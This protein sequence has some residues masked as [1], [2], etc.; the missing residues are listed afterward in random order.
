MGAVIRP[1]DLHPSG[2]AGQLEDRPSK[3]R[4]LIAIIGR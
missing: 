4:G 1:L 3:A 2:K